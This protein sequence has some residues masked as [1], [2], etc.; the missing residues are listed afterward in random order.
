MRAVR[1]V[2]KDEAETL[3]MVMMRMI[4]STVLMIG[5]W[6]IMLMMRMVMIKLTM[7]M[8]GIWKIMLMMRMVMIK[9]ML[10]IGITKED[11]A[12]GDDDDDYKDDGVNDDLIYFDLCLLIPRGT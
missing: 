9:L 12:H 6:K 4:K 3:I 8:I 11:K 1:D 10:M 5:I 2:G 7:L